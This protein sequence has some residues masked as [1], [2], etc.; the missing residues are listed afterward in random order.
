VIAEGP[1]YCWFTYSS[2]SS[3]FEKILLT[4]TFQGLPVI[5]ALILTLVSYFLVKKQIKN[6][7][8][9]ALENSYLRVLKVFWYPVILFVVFVPT[10]VDC[11][12]RIY[13]EERPMWMN[14]V[15]LVLPHSIGFLHAVL[16]GIQTKFGQKKYEDFGRTSNE[17]SNSIYL[18]FA[19]P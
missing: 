8:R 17:E 14:A 3:N 4:V 19:R 10:V 11:V 7:S 2:H 15:F 6:L 5:I 18:S 13:V 1:F 16:Y 9:G 12:R